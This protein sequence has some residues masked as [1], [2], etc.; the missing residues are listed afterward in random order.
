MCSTVEGRLALIGEAI[1]DVAATLSAGELS[2]AGMDDL[3]VRVAGIWSMLADLDPALAR[4]L[5]NYAP[6]AN[7][8][9]QRGEPEHDDIMLRPAG[10][11]W[12][13]QPPVT[14]TSS[15]ALTSGCRR[16]LT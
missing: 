12:P 5:R 2:S 3:T 9:P 7:D 16:T 10:R 4:R 8:Q 14:S 6:A 15:V 1:D 13:G 11:G